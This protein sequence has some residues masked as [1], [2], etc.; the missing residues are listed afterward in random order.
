MWITFLLEEHIFLGN[1]I[2][3][4]L[5]LSKVSKCVGLLD[6]RIFFPRLIIFLF[7]VLNDLSL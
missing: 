2:L 1:E 6:F 7:F 4:S 3:D 5:S